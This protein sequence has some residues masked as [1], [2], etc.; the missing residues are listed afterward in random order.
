MRFQ[1]HDEDGLL[2]SFWTRAEALA[3]KL[4]GMKLVVLPKVRRK[5][6]AEEFSEALALAGEATM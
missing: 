4:P 1:I 6:R 3:W 5:T 2:R